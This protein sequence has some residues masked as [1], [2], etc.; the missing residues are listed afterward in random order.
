M[1]VAE[2]GVAPEL[3]ENQPRSE[4]DEEKRLI[5]QLFPEFKK[6]EPEFLENPVVAGWTGGL[7]VYSTLFDS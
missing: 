1:D 5:W 3:K 4:K 2:S 6:L 7:R